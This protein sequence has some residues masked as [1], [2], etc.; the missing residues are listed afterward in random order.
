MGFK[1]IAIKILGE[2]SNNYSPGLSI[3]NLVLVT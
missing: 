3:L 1:P 2:D